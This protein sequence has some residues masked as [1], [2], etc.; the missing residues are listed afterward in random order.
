MSEFGKPKQCMHGCGQE[1]YFDAHSTIG[2]PSSDKW[3]PLEYN[4]G[5]KTDMA[6]D[7]PNRHNGSG[8]LPTSSQVFTKQIP[9][10]DNLAVIKQIAAASNEYIAIK[11]GGVKTT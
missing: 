2:H 1:I 9:T 10:T 5:L 7:C 3:I 11:E 6:H 8:Q 4:N